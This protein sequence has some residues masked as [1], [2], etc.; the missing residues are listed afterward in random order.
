LPRFNDGWFPTCCKQDLAA[1]VALRAMT[2][3]DDD[4]Q[5]TMDNN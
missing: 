4:C 1:D 2:K 3:F 5:E